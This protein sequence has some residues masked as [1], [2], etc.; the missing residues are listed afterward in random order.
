MYQLPC[1]VKSFP[2]IL[3]LLALTKN[4]RYHPITFHIP[5]VLILQGI[6]TETNKK[7]HRQRTH[8]PYTSF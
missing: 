7:A 5:M 3:V 8:T 1:L 6:Q 2:F 4:Q